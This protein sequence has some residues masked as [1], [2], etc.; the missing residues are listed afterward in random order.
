[1]YRVG[2]E[3]RTRTLPSAHIKHAAQ[4]SLVHGR[5]TTIRR[6]ILTIVNEG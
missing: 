4:C 6:D 1:M 5:T 3:K 2:I